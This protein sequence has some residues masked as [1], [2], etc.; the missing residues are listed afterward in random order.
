MRPTRTIE[1]SEVNRNK[2][3]E[4][5]YNLHCRSIDELITKILELIS[6]FKLGKELEDIDK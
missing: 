3:M 4:I 5:K 2:L 1:V 6:K